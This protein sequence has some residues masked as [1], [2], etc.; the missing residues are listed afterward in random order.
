MLRGK[1]RKEI[2]LHLPLAASIAFHAAFLGQEHRTYPQQKSEPKQS[3]QKRKGRL[4]EMSQAWRYPV[5][6]ESHPFWK[7]WEKTFEIS[8]MYISASYFRWGNQITAA[9]GGSILKG[10]EVP[11]GMAYLLDDNIEARLVERYK[12]AHYPDIFSAYPAPNEPNR[13]DLARLSRGTSSEQTDALSFYYHH[14]LAMDSQDIQN[15]AHMAQSNDLTIWFG[16]VTYL[17]YQ[18]YAGVNGKGELIIG[19]RAGNTERKKSKGPSVRIRTTGGRTP[20]TKVK[21]K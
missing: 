14:D 6:G 7:M 16:A 3:E 1:R 10:V 19:P 2:P 12:R 5:L 4:A 15:L 18:G 8:G 11:T 21:K 9:I 17:S 20:I 13:E